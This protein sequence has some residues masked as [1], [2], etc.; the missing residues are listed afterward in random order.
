MKTV[1]VAVLT[2]I[3]CAFVQP[4][5]AAQSGTFKEQILHSFA[6]GM[7]GAIPEA[8]LT[9]VNGILYGTT[10][11]GGADIGGGTVFAIDPG[12]GAETV[13]YSFCSQQNCTD[14]MEPWASLIYVG[15]ML[16]GTTTS[17]GTYNNGT[18]FSINPVTGAETVLH[19]FGGSPDGDGPLAGLIA[20]RGKLYGTTM[21]GGRAGLC[22][23]YGCG[24]VFSVERNTGA[25]K[26]LHSFGGRTDGFY[27]VAGLVEVGS[28]FYG[29]TYGGTAGYYGRQG[30]IFSLDPGTRAES[31]L[32]LFCSELGCAD[33]GFPY[34]GLIAVNGTLYG[35]ASADGGG[36]YAGAAFS[37]DPNA[38]TE[39]VLHA[40]TGSPD[41]KAPEGAL[42]DING[43]LYGTTYLGGLDYGTV[44]SLDAATGAETVLYSFCSGHHICP[45]DGGEPVA[46][47]I[48]VNGRLYGTTSGGGT[49]GYGT[50]FELKEKRR[51]A[52]N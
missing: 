45:G 4:V 19:S 31:V 26:V 36:Y 35:T 51:Q 39:T 14:G 27:P 28:I 16:Y 49:Y 8:G 10:Y 42:I 30:T 1:S 15:G 41:G 44:F 23:G 6:D 12:T 3:V 5:A 43:V 2:G 37:F 40:F 7:D 50:V 22:D 32:H 13:L 33:G 18:V 9:D 24:T 38:G 11:G 48:N 52:R 17:G 21:Y 46:G 20:V 29:T 34:A 47:L 25:E